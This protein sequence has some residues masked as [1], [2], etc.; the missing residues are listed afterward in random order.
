[1]HYSKQSNGVGNLRDYGHVRV[2]QCPIESPCLPNLAV[3]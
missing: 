1:M 2:N 3:N